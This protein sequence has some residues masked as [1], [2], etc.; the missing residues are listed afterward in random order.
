MKKLP[1]GT[2]YCWLAG[3]HRIDT[4]AHQPDKHLVLPKPRQR[5][6]RSAMTPSAT[7]QATT[8]P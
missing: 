7:I 1:F 8:R 4:W 6:T 5:Q 3:D 2:L